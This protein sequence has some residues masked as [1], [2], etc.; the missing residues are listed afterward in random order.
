MRDWVAATNGM[1][2]VDR[3]IDIRNALVHRHVPTGVTLRMGGLP[4]YSIRVEE[5]EGDVDVDPG[6]AYNLA[7]DRFLSLGL[8]LLDE[9]GVVGATD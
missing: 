8:L 4:S 2:E 3:L 9:V 1:P 7:V 6:A 5:V